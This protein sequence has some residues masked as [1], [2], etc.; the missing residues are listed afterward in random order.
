MGG[1][2]CKGLEEEEKRR[3]AADAMEARDMYATE[4]KERQCEEKGPEEIDLTL[5]WPFVLRGVECEAAPS[6]DEAGWWA[7]ERSALRHER[8]TV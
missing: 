7:R 4:R 2:W 1:M 6:R 3:R 8:G 5:G